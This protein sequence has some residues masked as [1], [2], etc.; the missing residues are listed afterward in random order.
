MDMLHT[1]SDGTIMM[2]REVIFHDNKFPWHKDQYEDKEALTSFLGSILPEVSSLSSSS[3][4]F[5]SSSS[6]LFSS[7]SSSPVL[8]QES[9]D[10]TL[11]PVYFQE[12][13]QQALSGDDEWEEGQE[14]GIKAFDFEDQG[15]LSPISP[16]ATPVHFP[17]QLQGVRECMLII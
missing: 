7:S 10:V 15:M 14:E 8:S 9:R 1:T 16:S 4:S 6:S 17:P 12:Q 5:S 2:T 13:S 11:P 3:T